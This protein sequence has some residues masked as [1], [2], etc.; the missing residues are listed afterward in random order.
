[1]NYLALQDQF[2]YHWQRARDLWTDDSDLQVTADREHSVPKPDRKRP[3]C[4]AG[5]AVEDG[6]QFRAMT[7]SDDYIVALGRGEFEPP[8]PVFL[9]H[10]NFLYK[11]FRV[12][13][14]CQAGQH[15]GRSPWTILRST[16]RPQLLDDRRCRLTPVA[17]EVLIIW[18]LFKFVIF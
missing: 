4:D 18:E 16:K 17:H 6:N 15:V 3:Y 11:R 9:D 12:G 2:V 1:M 13:N 5:I 7:C 8:S 14:C 10:L